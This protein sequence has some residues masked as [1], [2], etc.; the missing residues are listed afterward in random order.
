MFTKSKISKLNPLFRAIV[1]NET[2]GL[3]LAKSG[4]KA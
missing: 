3:L 4:I 2:M 1:T